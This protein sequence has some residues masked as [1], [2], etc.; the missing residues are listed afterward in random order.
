M[1]LVFEL[2]NCALIV[3]CAFAIFIACNKLITKYYLN[4]G[5]E[6]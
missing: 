4:D 1:N 2:F 3:V 6:E 5:E